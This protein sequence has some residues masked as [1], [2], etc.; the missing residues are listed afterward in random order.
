[1]F[2]TEFAIRVMKTQYICRIGILWSVS[3]ILGHIS[4][5]DVFN[6]RLSETFISFNSLGASIYILME[7]YTRF[8]PV[9]C[10][11]YRY[12]IKDEIKQPS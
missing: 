11:S 8:V 6:R 7:F 12:C 3:L 4:C 9:R 1:M 2:Y 5:F 10:R